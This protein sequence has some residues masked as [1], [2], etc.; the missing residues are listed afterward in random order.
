MVPNLIDKNKAISA[1][2]EEPV[3]WIGSDYELGERNQWRSDRAAIEAIDCEECTYHFGKWVEVHGY[4]SPGGTPIFVCGTC[5]GSEHQY[6]IEFHHRKM[7]C[8][9]CG[10]INSYPWEKTLEEQI[11]EEEKWKKTGTNG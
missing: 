10:S 1:L 7:V 9:D 3:V 5:G 11:Q 4:A 8:Y 6:G 2:G